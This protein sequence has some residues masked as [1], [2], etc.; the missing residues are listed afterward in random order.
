LEERKIP[1]PVQT[2]RMAE[3]DFSSLSSSCESRLGTPTSRAAHERRKELR[4]QRVDTKNAAKMRLIMEKVFQSTK[5]DSENNLTS[6]LEMQKIDPLRDQEEGIFIFARKSGISLLQLPIDVEEY[7]S[8][9]QN[10]D[11]VSF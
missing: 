5:F 11:R 3:D 6:V 8:N 7:L 9:F 10:V 1:S 4:M 2:D